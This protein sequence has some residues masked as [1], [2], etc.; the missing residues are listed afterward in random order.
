MGR[1]E[2]ITLSLPSSLAYLDAVQGMAE[3]LAC[4][5]GFD[6]EAR[7]DVGL[8]V[9]EGAINA[10]KHGNRLDPAKSVC[11]EF[12]L[13]AGVLKIAIRDEGAGFEPQQTPDPTAP[14]NLWRSSGR[15]L[16]LIRSLVNEV[17]FRRHDPGMELILIK[18]RPA[19]GQR[20]EEAS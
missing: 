11:I 19:D 10:I 13:T 18:S 5:A 8:A 12:R 16:L 9:R 15:G 20:D 7:L 6:E 1:E 17:H 2:T 14:E 3:L 4:T